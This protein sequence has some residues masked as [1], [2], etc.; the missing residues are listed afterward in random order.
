M[1]TDAEHKTVGQVPDSATKIAS[2]LLLTQRIAHLNDAD[3]DPMNVD[4]PSEA[5]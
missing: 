4:E 3:E 2:K 5:Y 1:L